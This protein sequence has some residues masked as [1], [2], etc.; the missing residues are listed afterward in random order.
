[1]STITLRHNKKLLSTLPKADRPPTTDP[2]CNCRIKTACP[3]DGKCKQK[4]IVY[5]A[6]ISSNNTTKFY[7]GSSSTDFKT[8]FSNRKH[9]FTHRNKKN[10]TELSKEVWRAKDNGI[11]PSIKWSIVSAAPSYNFKKS[12][13]NLCLAE[14]LAI[15]SGDRKIMLSKR[16]EITNTCRHRKKFK[17]KSIRLDSSL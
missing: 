17:L 6:E 1:M 16:F 11:E 4:S 12:K 2:K 15:L 14:K 8:R 7:Y 9:S 3:L 5:K 10:A 13:C